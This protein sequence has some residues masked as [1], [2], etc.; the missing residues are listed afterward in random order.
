MISDRKRCQYVTFPSESLWSVARTQSSTEQVATHI[1][2]CSPGNPC[3]YLMTLN[4]YYELQTQQQA[5]HLQLTYRHWLLRKY[6]SCIGRHICGL[7]EKTRKWMPSILSYTNI[8]STITA[9][10]NCWLC[11]GGPFTGNKTAGAW[12]W[13]LTHI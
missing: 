12:S 4:Q 5:K 2:C 9:F 6:T 13:S 3:G 1:S 11:T 10:S 8:H 7:K